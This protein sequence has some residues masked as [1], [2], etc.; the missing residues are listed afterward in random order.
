MLEISRAL[1]PFRTTF[2]RTLRLIAFTGEEYG[3]IGSKAYVKQHARELDSIRFV[4]NL[5]GLFPQTAQG[6]AVMWAPAMRDY[7]EKA[8]RETQC[9]VDVQNMFCMSSDYV[10]FMLAG[11]VTARQADLQDSFPPWSHTRH[12]TPDKI[13]PDW[14]RLNAM[15]YAQ[16][17]ARILTDPRPLPT[18]RLSPEEVRTLVEKED[19]REALEAWENEIPTC[20]QRDY[21]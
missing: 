5:D 10:P 13:P 14:I 21:E 12:D 4:L 17:L 15:T 7:I 8:F 3:L 6:M 9:D 20:S 2:R 16:L 1:A 11:I 19:A 18:K